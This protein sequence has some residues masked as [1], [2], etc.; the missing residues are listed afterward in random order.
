MRGTETAGGMAL[1]IPSYS[2]KDEAEADRIGLLYMARAGY[3]PRAAPR[4][5]KRVAEDE[6]KKEPA[7]I[8]ATHP[9]SYD[10]YKALTAQLPAAMEEYRRVT[11]TYPPNYTPGQSGQG[12]G[13]LNTGGGGQ[14]PPRKDAAP[15][16]GSPSVKQGKYIRFE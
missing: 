11:G 13:L 15:A 3:D 4:I 7:S 1:Y 2:R 6:G 12:T 9:S 5:W 14:A 10:R 8:F 16:R